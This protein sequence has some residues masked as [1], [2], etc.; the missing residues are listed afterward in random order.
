MRSGERSAA[1]QRERVYSSCTTWELD[2]ST[3][4]AACTPAVGAAM[5]GR[6]ERRKEEETH[7]ERK[8]KAG[9]GLQAAV[10]R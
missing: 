5:R 6:F 4:T 3:A 10:S 7:G 8:R 2:V 9:L 1:S